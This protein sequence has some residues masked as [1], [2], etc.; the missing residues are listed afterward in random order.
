MKKRLFCLGLIIALVFS[1]AACTGEPQSETNQG[2]NSSQG[3]LESFAY[4]PCKLL[5]WEISPSVDADAQ[6]QER[7]FSMS[8]LQ[9][10]IEYQRNAAPFEEFDSDFFEEKSLLIFR[11]KAPYLGGQALL[12]YAYTLDNGNSITVNAWYHC[13][14]DPNAGNVLMLVQLDRDEYTDISVHVSYANFEFTDSDVLI[15]LTKEATD[16][17]TFHDYT[18]EDFPELNAVEVEELTIYTNARI[19]ECLLEDPTGGTIPDHLKNNKR[20]FLIRLTEKSKENVLRAV[21]ILLQR[22]DIETA[23]PN[24]IYHAEDD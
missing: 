16:A 18:V 6:M 5:Y 12:S 23:G 21:N 24:Y 22:D 1:F 17:T 8:E 20:C 14:I 3:E 13:G 2:E 7:V 10:S 4:I 11:F 9:S 15:W 19:R